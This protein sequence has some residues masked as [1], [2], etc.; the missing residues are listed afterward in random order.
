MTPIVSLIAAIGRNRELGKRGAEQLLW[1]IPEDFAHF[2]TITMGKPVIMGSK[3]YESIGKPLPGRHNI[4]IAQAE[5]YTAPGCTVVHSIDDAV[6][7]ANKAGS[8]EVFFIGGGYVY[9]QA[10]AYADRLYLT[11]IDADFP[12]ADLF[13][14]PYDDFI[15]VSEEQGEN[16]Q[17]T[18]K[19]VTLERNG[20]SKDN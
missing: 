3:T 11:L 17:Y 16:E 12:T 7:A 1:H 5:A 14:P 18:Y 15:V 20:Y 10:I 13:F 9:A 2:K 8:N 4:V 6:A 19:F